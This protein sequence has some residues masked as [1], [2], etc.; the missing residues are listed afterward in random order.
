MRTV[1][2]RLQKHW[3]GGG[4]IRTKRSWFAPIFF[5][6]MLV[7]TS[8]L[9]A[10]DACHDAVQHYDAED[11]PNSTVVSLFQELSDRG[12]VR[13]TMWIARLYMGGRCS[14]PKNVDLAQK[15]ATNAIVGVRQLAEKG[16]V[17]AEFL[18]GA[19][20]QEGLGVVE[21]PEEAV[22]WL[23]KSADGGQI[24]AMN[25]LGVMLTMGNGIEPDIK[26]ARQL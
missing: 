5:V 3:P 11:L 23:T 21:N 25:N 22:K 19:A 9:A 20:Y 14:L 18:L 1:N 13:G 16:D 17:E 10:P 6:L 12:D 24:T 2:I 15:M 7:A 26:R 4:S 8:G